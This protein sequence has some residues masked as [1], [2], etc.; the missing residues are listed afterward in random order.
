MQKMS[1]TVVIPVYGVRPPGFEL[2][3]IQE[4]IN[5]IRAMK[6]L[7]QNR[8]TEKPEDFIIYDER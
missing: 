5:K 7:E 3:R 8:K 2:Y 4:R 1:R 6:L